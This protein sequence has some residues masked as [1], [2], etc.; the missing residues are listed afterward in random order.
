MGEKVIADKIG[1]S[2]RYIGKIRIFIY[3]IIGKIHKN[4]R[5]KKNIYS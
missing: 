1:E 2:N 5:N 3:L 4:I